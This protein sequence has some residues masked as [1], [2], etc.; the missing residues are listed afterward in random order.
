MRNVE[1]ALLIMELI[2]MIF[3]FFTLWHKIF[4]PQS[5]YMGAAL[6]AI[7]M[8][9]SLFF[10]RSRKL[11]FIQ[12]AALFFLIR[13]IYNI[14]MNFSVIPFGDGNWDYGVVKLFIQEGNVFIIKEPTRLSLYSSWPLLHTLAAILS[15]ISG[16]DAFYIVLFLPS[17]IS[18]TSFIFVYLFVRIIEKSLKLDRLTTAMALLLYTVSP[19]SIFWP[20][21]FVRQH[22][23]ILFSTM[24]LYMVTK[25]TKYFSDR[26]LTILL[27]FFTF[28]LIISHHF[29]SFIVMLYLFVLLLMSSIF[30]IVKKYLQL[31][32]PRTFR[33]IHQH[34]NILNVCLTFACFLLI[35]WNH[36][37]LVIWPYITSG[38]ERLLKLIM[39]MHEMELMPRLAVYPNI[40][41]PHWAS[42]LLLLRDILIYL[43]TSLGLFVIIK[44]APNM[45]EKFLILYY[46]LAFGLLIVLDNLIFRVGAMRVV[47][48]SLQFIVLP[49]AIPY[50]YILTKSKSLW[51]ISIM[52]ILSLLIFS[53]FIGLWGHNFA[54]LH[55][56]DP[57]IDSLKVG[58][59]NKDFIR[60]GEFQRQI[61]VKNFNVV[62]TDDRSPMP[63]ILDPDDYS[64]IQLLPATDIQKL[65]NYGSEI[66]YLF[67]N[68]NMYCYYAATFSPVDDPEEA[69]IIGS[70]IRQKLQLK[71]NCVYNDGK[72]EIW[73]NR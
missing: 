48:L 46:T 22:M 12:I 13:N 55:L 72:N 24:V 2:I 51:K 47:A 66:V 10:N 62:W 5:Y 65:G 57:N 31:N 45:P 29:S 9:G 44:K 40:L 7:L 18:I 30:L 17:L 15:S 64:K 61:P 73:I 63:F 41:T 20:M 3:V 69:E 54:P 59:S 38:I 43:P 32:S 37:A 11:A 27:F 68:S 39:G 1:K 16:L 71:F 52:I 8:A 19:E 23:G 50:S 42:S 36:V 53:S 21:Q 58:E 25:F 14:S 4:L 28:S 35:W 67:K 33:G 26:K 60:V 34:I 49:S 6:L 56:Y 70:V